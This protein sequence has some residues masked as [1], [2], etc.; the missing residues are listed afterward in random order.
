MPRWVLVMSSPGRSCYLKSDLV[1]LICINIFI[2]SLWSSIFENIL[3][4]FN[5][6]VT[7][8][9]PSKGRHCVNVWICVSSVFN[10]HWR[11]FCT[12]FY[13][14]F[15]LC[16]ILTL[17]YA[18]LYTSCVRLFRSCLKQLCEEWHVLKIFQ[19]IWVTKIIIKLHW[20]SQKWRK[21]IEV[22][23]S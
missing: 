10:V 12:F 21:F 6:S 16:D 23:S 11:F 7:G 5:M 18:C 19:L 8:V 9:F 15:W 2:I 4:W 3:L 1:C 14:S 17:I 22:L 20:N 13:S